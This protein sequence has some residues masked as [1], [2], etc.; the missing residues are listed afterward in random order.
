MV[1]VLLFFSAAAANAQFFFL[2]AEKSE[3]FDDCFI[4]T[5]LNYKNFPARKKSNGKEDSAKEQAA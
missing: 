3:F 1:S 5:F 4:I 2:S